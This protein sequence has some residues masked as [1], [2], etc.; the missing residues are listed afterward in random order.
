MKDNK[1]TAG[2][3]FSNNKDFIKIARGMNLTLL[4]RSADSR[5]LRDC[6]EN[7]EVHLSASAVLKDSRST[8]AGIARLPDG[9]QVFIKRYNNKGLRY[10]LRYMF[11]NAKA[12]RTWQAA[13]FFE[14]NNIP[15]P[16]PI[17]ASASRAAGILISAYLVTE[18]VPDLIPT[19]DFCRTMFGSRKVQEVF[20]DSVCSLLSRMH[21]AGIYHG[22]AKLS[23]IYVSSGAKGSYSFGMWDLD[24]VDIRSKPICENLRASEI[25]RTASSYIEIGNRLGEKS[26][27]EK[28]VRMFVNS[29][30]SVSSTAPDHGAILRKTGKYLRLK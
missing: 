19:L 23:N 22:D 21:D 15:T 28:T 17:A 26:D 8:K 25:A 4:R 6:I 14:M 11:L 16:R 13:W 20:S 3:C 10:T 18:S 24:G 27:V 1:L 9:R 30:S 7:P 29:Y 2:Y 12:F 5:E